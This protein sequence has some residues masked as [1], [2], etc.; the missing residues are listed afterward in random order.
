MS[1]TRKFLCRAFLLLWV[2]SLC[3]AVGQAVAQEPAGGPE[4][5]AEPA[6][7]EE[8]ADTLFSLLVKG[9]VVMIPIGICSVIALALTVERFISLSRTR[10]IPPQFLSGL[11]KIFGGRTKQT[12][13][14]VGYCDQN[15]CPISRVFKAGIRRL[16]HGRETMEKAI[17]DAGAR[18]FY[19]MRQSLKP[20]AVIAAI[21]PLLGLLG[22]VYG[23]IIAFQSAYR[24]GVG[25]TGEGLARG[26]YRALVTTAAGLTLAIP[27]LIVYQMLISRVDKLVDDMDDQAIEF[28]EYTVYADTGDQ[29]KPP[30]KRRRAGTTS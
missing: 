30:A 1:E 27:V 12:E 25:R 11:K 9:G 29:A 2:L 21:S 22:T 18:E 5:G 14:A 15:P 23:M 13:P 28:L 24:A 3:L 7:P 17:E 20:L 6:V 16:P 10:I 19:K 4:P 26:I 8:E